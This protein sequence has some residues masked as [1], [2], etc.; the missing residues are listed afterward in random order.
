MIEFSDGIFM[1]GGATY[2]LDVE[3]YSIEEIIEDY[4]DDC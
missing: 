4:D 2:D 1:Y 3:Y